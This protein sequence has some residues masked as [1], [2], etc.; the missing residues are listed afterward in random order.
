M[1]ILFI[2]NFYQV[3]RSGGE[4]QSCQQVVKGLQ[5]RGHAT[6]VLTSMDGT[7]N[8][9]VETD[10]VHRSL[11]LEMDLVPWR[12]SLIFFTKRKAREK[13]NLEVFERAV[14]QFAADIIFI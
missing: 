6:L 5:E 7:N 1:R 4:D 14:E 10:G 9:P 13:H 12:H 11:Y 8:V 2:T 3:N